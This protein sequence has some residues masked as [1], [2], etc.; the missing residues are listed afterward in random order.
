M[1]GIA[2]VAL[3]VFGFFVAFRLFFEKNKEDRGGI[4]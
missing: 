1:A 4:R 3:V 2:D